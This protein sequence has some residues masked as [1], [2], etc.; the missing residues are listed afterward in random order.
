MK[1]IQDTNFLK[2]FYEKFYKNNER[3]AYPNIE[4]YEKINL[5][6]VQAFYNERFQNSGNFTFAIVGDFR[7]EEIETLVMK[8]IGSLNFKNHEDDFIDQ[9]IRINLNKE[10]IN[11]EEE[12]SVKATVSRYYNKKFTNTFSE[13]L[14]NKILLS[15]IDKLMFNEIRE[16]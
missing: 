6:D 5:K 7:F 16:K 10:N 4:Y 13:R 1:K 8:Y 9:N 2:E 14:K 11:Y 12:S 3:V 15:V